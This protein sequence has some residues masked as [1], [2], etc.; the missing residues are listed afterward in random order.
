MKVKFSGQ[1]KEE[2]L[3]STRGDTLFFESLLNAY[4]TNLYTLRGLPSFTLINNK[5]VDDIIQVDEKILFLSNSELYLFPNTLITNTI[6]AGLPLT[7]TVI[8]GVLYFSNGQ[9]LYIYDFNNLTEVPSGDIDDFLMYIPAGFPIEHDKG[10][11]LSVVGN[12]IYFSNLWQFTVVDKRTNL[13]QMN[14]VVHLLCSVSSGL[15]IGTE[16]G[17][18]LYTYTND[19][20]T[21]TL[22]KLS[23][24]KARSI[25]YILYNNI[26]LFMSNKGLLAY[27]GGELV[28]ITKNKHDDIEYLCKLVFLNLPYSESVAIYQL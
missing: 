14:D 8:N 24:L 10:R 2:P 26:Y 1:S 7:Y 4:I 9:T 20:M 25:N 5:P 3:V 15:L 22:T 19:F 18:F 13:I 16:D 6:P 21:G 17:I 12:N 28:N 23:D 27:K 11:L